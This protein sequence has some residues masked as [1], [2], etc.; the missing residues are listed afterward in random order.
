MAFRYLPLSLDDGTLFRL[1]PHLMCPGT[2]VTLRPAVIV[3]AIALVTGSA[4]LAPRARSFLAS[5]KGKVRKARV[6]FTYWGWKGTFPDLRT[7]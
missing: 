6:E 3:A 2:M 7:F 5:V 4:P 1:L